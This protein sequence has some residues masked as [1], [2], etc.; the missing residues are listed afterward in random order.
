[1]DDA[2]RTPGK[3]KNAKSVPEVTAT[4]KSRRNGT[5]RRNRTGK[6]RSRNCN[7]K[8]PFDRDDTT[9]DFAIGNIISQVSTSAIDS[10]RRSLAEFN[11]NPTNT[12]LT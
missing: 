5:R 10:R 3:S 7:R 4:K 6:K 2:T 9:D 8:D 12:S 11:V 1:M